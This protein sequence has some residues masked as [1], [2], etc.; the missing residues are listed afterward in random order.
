[1]ITHRINFGKMRLSF[2]RFFAGM[3]AN[4]GT[5][6][7]AFSFDDAYVD[8]WY[9]VRDLFNRYG[10]KVTFFV[11]QFDLLTQESIEKLKILQA[12]GHEIGFHGL[13]HLSAGKFV[14][15]NSLDKYL[16]T[17]ILPGIDAMTK[18]AFQP[19]TFSYPY[20]VRTPS[21]DKALLKYFKHVRGVICTN[22]K[23]RLSDF[24][25]IYYNNRNDGLIFAA[26]IDNIY[27]NSVEEI[28][29][30]IGKA[31]KKKMTLLLYAHRVSNAPG[32]Y[33]VP[34]A[35]LEAVFKYASENGLKFYKT[36]DL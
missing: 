26:G 35:R 25:Q 14:A 32:D 6:G 31:I 29:A 5:A 2:D 34:A 11:S 19:L 3:G 12:D 18:H 15:E 21:I 17:E 27:A 20:G 23:K 30:A 33:C 13:R 1:M 22:E 28:Q 24:K 9:S 4:S 8:E 10:A 16:A 36:S 7:I